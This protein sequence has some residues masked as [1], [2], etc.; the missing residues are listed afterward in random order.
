V[1]I[2]SISQHAG[3]SQATQDFSGSG[4]AAASTILTKRLCRILLVEGWLLS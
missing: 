1:E 4:T 3:W 2:E